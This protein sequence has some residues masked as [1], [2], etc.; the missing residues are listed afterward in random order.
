M[1]PIQDIGKKLG[2]TGKSVIPWGHDKAKIDYESIDAAASNDDGK[3]LAN[4]LN[5]QHLGRL[6][7]LDIWFLTHFETPIA[8]RQRSL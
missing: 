3:F 5:R 6:G 1:L 4:V 2:I 7:D 8:L